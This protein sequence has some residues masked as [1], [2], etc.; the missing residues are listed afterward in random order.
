V[1]PTPFIE[2]AVSF[3]KY[4]FGSSVENHM[5]I[6]IDLLFCPIDLC[7]RFYAGSM[8]FLLLWIHSTVEVRYCNPS[9]IALFLLR[10]GLAIHCLLYF[11]MKF[12]GDFSISVKN[13]IG[14]FMEI[15]LTL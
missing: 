1:F 9:S 5:A 3:P 11:H 7:V 13:D 6:A 4:G 12:R 8:L 10:I 15:A 2:K 14:I